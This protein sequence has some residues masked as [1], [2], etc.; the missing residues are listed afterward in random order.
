MEKLK[1]NWPKVAAGTLILA[2]L[3]YYVYKG[4]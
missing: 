1:E 4:N 2:A 3:G